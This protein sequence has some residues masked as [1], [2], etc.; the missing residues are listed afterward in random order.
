[1]AGDAAD[2]VTAQIQLTRQAESSDADPSSR[3]PDPS[4]NLSRARLLS[5]F[6]V[7]RIYQYVATSNRRFGGQMQLRHRGKSRSARANLYK[8]P[9]QAFHGQRCVLDTL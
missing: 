7:S 5:G 2:A 1:M 9:T 3:A 6:G 4:P 8:A